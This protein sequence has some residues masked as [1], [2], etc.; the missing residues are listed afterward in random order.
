MH[1]LQSP[2]WQSFQKQMNRQTFRQ[3]GDGWEYLAILEKG[4]RNSR[5]Y[6]PYGPSAR[7]EKS[8]QQAI[9]SLFSLADR[10]SVTFIRVEP[11]NSAYVPYLESLGA[12]KVTYQS[13][14][15]EHTNVIDLS[16]NK[17]MLVQKMSQP[18]RNIYRN[19]IKKDLHVK[20]STDPMSI[21][22]LSELLDEVSAKTGMKPHSSDYFW[23]QATS[24]F[25]I[26]AAKLW[27]VTYMDKPIAA[28]LMYDSDNT[29]YYAHAAANTSPEYRK[30]NAGTALLAEAIIDAKNKG[31]TQFDLF[32][33]APDGSSPEHPWAGFTRFKRSFGGQDVSF[34]GSW[35]IPVKQFDYWLYR[36]FQTIRRYF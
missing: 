19:Y 11:L 23:A 28:A 16:I 36:S 13:L 30:L 15:P 26:G 7:D 9:D 29:R 20:T 12:K 33:I 14:N 21:D 8:F 35:D 6:C 17:D 22:I 24:L 25:P 27:Y 34:G 5:L 32:G 31:L 4:S 10:Q 1:F 2:A 3:S 18:V